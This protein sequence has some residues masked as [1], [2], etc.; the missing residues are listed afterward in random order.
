M[1]WSVQEVWYQNPDH[2][3]NDCLFPC[4]CANC[5]SDHPLCA[6]YCEGWRQ[7]KGALT[8]KHY[9]NIP[10]YEARKL[11]VNSKTS[12]YSQADQRIKFS[13][14]YEMI[15]KTLI[16]LESSDWGSF[17]NKIKATL[18][19]IRAEDASTT[20]LDLADEKGESSA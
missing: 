18:Y 11:V 13:Y 20:S 16:Q 4:K 1:A 7:E 15:V 9:N 5:G 12:T 6:R 19:I 17:I 3:I 8:I 10:Y 2:H 14:K